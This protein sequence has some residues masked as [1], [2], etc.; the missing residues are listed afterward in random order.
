MGGGGG[1]LNLPRSVFC[2]GEGLIYQDLYFARGGG[3]NSYTKIS[4]LQGCMCQWG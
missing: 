1:G 3:V 2:K 4:I